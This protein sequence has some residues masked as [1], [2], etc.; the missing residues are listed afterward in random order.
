MVYWLRCISR[1]LVP[2]N[3]LDTQL[4]SLLLTDRGLKISKIANDMEMSVRK[5][6]TLH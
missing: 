6:G 1:A 3:V 2:V 5:M 4:S